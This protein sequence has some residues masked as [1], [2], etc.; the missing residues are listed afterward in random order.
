MKIDGRGQDLAKEACG[1]TRTRNWGRE[2]GKPG[3]DHRDN[4]RS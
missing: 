1:E 4:T 2:K 3:C